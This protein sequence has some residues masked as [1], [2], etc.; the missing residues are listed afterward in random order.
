M[1]QTVLLQLWVQPD[2]LSHEFG[3]VLSRFIIFKSYNSK[4]DAQKDQYEFTWSKLYLII[5]LS[6][7]EIF[8]AGASVLPILTVFYPQLPTSPKRIKIVLLTAV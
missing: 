6:K 3:R 5:R 1:L 2:K 4:Y 7:A 8:K